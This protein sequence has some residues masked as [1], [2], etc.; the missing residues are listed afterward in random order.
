MAQYSLSNDS[1]FYSKNYNTLVA[2]IEELLG[3]G[4]SGISISGE[5]K[6]KTESYWYLDLSNLDLTESGYDTFDEFMMQELSGLG[7]GR[8][9]YSL[10]VYGN[11]Y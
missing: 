3:N 4:V 10:Q 5:I 9:Y 6:Y 7:Y 1:Y 2:L 8:L 11:I